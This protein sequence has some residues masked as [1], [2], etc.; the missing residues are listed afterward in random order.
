ME[1][2]NIADKTFTRYWKFFGVGPIAGCISLCLLALL[3]LLDRSLG[4]LRIM[5]HPLPIRILG[6]VLIALQICWHLWCMKTIKKWW[7][8]DQLCTTGPY[9]YV[10]H[11][12]YAGW[13]YLGFIGLILMFN[14]WMMLLLPLLQYPLL[15]FLVR[16]EETMMTGIFGEE[17][18]RYA[19]R[20]GRLFPRLFK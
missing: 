6:A 13:L 14:S 4:H 12:I 18:S 7:F 8:G 9:R 16:P 5:A 15:S 11:P 19:A 20:T 1:R 3:W 10:R 17:Y 2:K